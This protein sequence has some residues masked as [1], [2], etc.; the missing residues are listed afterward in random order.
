MNCIMRTTV[1]LDDRLGEAVKA[2]AAREGL[3]LSAF[4]ARVLR[5]ALIK[6]ERPPEPKP[7]RLITA[8]GD[9][10]APGVNLDRTNE[11]LTEDDVIAHKR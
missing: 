8:G 7:F 10:P 6:S 11:L 2:A 9:G 5:D 4:V 1:S 3:S